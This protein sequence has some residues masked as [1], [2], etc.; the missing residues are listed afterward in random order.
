MP[1]ESVTPEVDS[2]SISVFR[3][4]VKLHEVLMGPEV[5]G[6]SKL[7]ADGPALT[8]PEPVYPQRSYSEE[9]DRSE[10]DY[11]HMNAWRTWRSWGKP[12]FASRSLKNRR[13]RP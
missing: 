3:I 12:Y 8:L 2:D 9:T 5:E 13:R 7:V 6:R 4:D 10:T 11:Q 1:K